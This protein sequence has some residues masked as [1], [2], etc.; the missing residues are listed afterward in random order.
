MESWQRGRLS[1]SRDRW[2]HSPLGWL[3]LCIL[4]GYSSRVL[5]P[6]GWLSVVLA[7]LGGLCL[8]SAYLYG[9]SISGT[10]GATRWSGRLVALSLGFTLILGA[11]LYYSHTMQTLERPLSLER[12]EVMARLIDSPSPRD[13][14]QNWDVEFLS[15]TGRGRRIRLYT[16]DTLVPQVGDSLVLRIGHY[17]GIGQATPPSRY[18]DYLL[19]LGL[20]GT[21]RGRS[22]AH[23]PTP[24]AYLLASQ[25][26][27]L[28]LRC[29]DYLRTRLGQ[30]GLSP[31]AES[32]LTGIALGYIPRDSIGRS[33][34]GEFTAGAVAHLLAVSGFHLA[35]VVGTLTLI[36]GCIPGMRRHHRL[37]WGIVLLGAWAFTLLTGC[38]IPTLRAAL[39]LTLYAGARGLGRPTSLPEV[40]ALPALIQLLISP[41]SLL[42]V[43]LP[44]TYLAL[45]G[46]YLFYQPIYRS[47]GRL[48][49]RPLSYL[50]SGIALTL[51]V[52]PLVLPLSLYFFGY[53]SLSFVFTSLPLTLLAT[54]LI[55]VT[56]VV[57]LLLAVGVASLPAPLIAGLEELAQLMRGLTNAFANVPLLHLRYSLSLGELVGLYALLMV[58]LLLARLRAEYHRSPTPAPVES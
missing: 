19:S 14:G 27:L 2:L 22:I 54:L 47:V 15:G 35:V 51:S 46:I 28:A 37:R 56:L 50:W 3:L 9:W 52:Q 39:M 58:V 18:R 38:T 4:L 10:V 53:S 32:V 6:L 26:T 25:P 36:L 33:I 17:E 8:L 23:H 24:R 40:L 11:R 48:R 45:L 1:A 30:I 16:Q 34:R 7:T 43:S 12:G 44:L 31:Y 29:R 20:S 13:R 49:S 57:L 41:T 21:A 42:S 5:V 55:P